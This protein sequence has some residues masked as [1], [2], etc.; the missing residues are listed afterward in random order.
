MVWIE[1]VNGK[2]KAE[3]KLRE[4]IAPDAISFIVGFGH[5]GYGASDYEVDGQIIKGSKQRKAGST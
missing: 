5:N 3:V 2:R 1:S 4:G